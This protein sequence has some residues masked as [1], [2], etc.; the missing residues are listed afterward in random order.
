MAVPAEVRVQIER[1]LAGLESVEGVRI[2]YAVESGSRAWGFASAD[3]DFD[4]R[5]IYVRPQPW[6]LAIDLET[7]RDVIERPLVDELDFSGWDLRKALGLFGRSNPPLLEWLDSPVVYVDRLR[8]AER[9]RTLIPAYFSPISVM[10]HY[11]RMARGNFR[12]DLQRERVRLKKYFYVLRPLLAARWV[13]Q[14]RGPVP[15]EFA[16]LL[17]AVVDAPTLVEAI[18]S[19]VARKLASTELDDGP[20]VPVLQEFVT[21]ELERLE[22][23]AGSL[24]KGRGEPEPLNELF[25]E[26]LERAWADEQAAS[27][28]VDRPTE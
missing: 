12:S 10:H 3:S 19:L 4:V 22:A 14:G 28:G 9:L 6:Y 2:L 18:H 24:A 23:I 15:M 8:F 27:R 7:R 21:A 17:E 13:E 25:R 16:R 26:Y 20:P 5:F 1:Q 11:L